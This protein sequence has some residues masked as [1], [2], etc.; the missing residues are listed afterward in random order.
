MTADSVLN[1]TPDY[2]VTHTFS[3]NDITGTFDGLTQG[4]VVP[5]EIPI[6]DFSAAPMVT[7]DGVDLFPI[8]SEFGFVVT[9]FDG[10]VQKDFFDNP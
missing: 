3:T 6:I 2:T 5:G 8:N 4:D 10:A 1:L 9:D 7:K